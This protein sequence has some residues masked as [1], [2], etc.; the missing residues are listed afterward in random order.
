[1][2]NF[3]QAQSENSAEAQKKREEIKNIHTERPRFC[4]HCGAPLEDDNDF[5]TECG[6]RIENEVSVEEE[7]GEESAVTKESRPAPKI[8]SDR[9]AS[10]MET[11][12]VKSGGV[13]DEFKKNKVEAEKANQLS[14]AKLTAQTKSTLKTGYYVHKDSEKTQYLIIK[15]VCGKS[16]SASVKTTFNDG[17]YSTE[18]YTG[19]IS[20]DNIELNVL[21]TDLHPLPNQRWET[22]TGITTVTHSI[23]VSEHFSGTFSEDKIAGNFSGEYNQ[24]VVFTKE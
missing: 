3:A 8:S 14:I 23:R 13:T 18:H 1:M 16:V 21:G 11:A 22:M 4:I 7:T 10:I 20:G 24:F 5:C 2:I 12:R 9:L 6:E 17:G 15:S 19:T